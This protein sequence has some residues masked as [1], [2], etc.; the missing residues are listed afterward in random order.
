V[1]ADRNA[2]TNENHCEKVMD[3]LCKCEIFKELARLTPVGLHR[4]IHMY[5]LVKKVRDKRPG[6]TNRDVW[7]LMESMFDCDRLNQ[8]AACPTCMH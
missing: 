4:H 6:V 5:G 3:E 1:S 7:G 2:Q 8:R